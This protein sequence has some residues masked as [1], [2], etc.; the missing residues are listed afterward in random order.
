MGDSNVERRG[1]PRRGAG[2]VDL[3]HS[4]GNILQQS[5][6]DTHRS[7]ISSNFLTAQALFS[8]EIDRGGGEAAELSNGRDERKHA[9]VTPPTGEYHA[10]SRDTRMRTSCTGLQHVNSVVHVCTWLEA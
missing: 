1:R 6:E 5:T 10:S 4:H 2:E 8:R 3:Q 9:C 7:D